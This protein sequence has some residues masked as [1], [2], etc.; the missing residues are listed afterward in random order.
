M[1]PTEELHAE[2]DSPAAE[3]ADWQRVAGTGERGEFCRAWLNIQA[4]LV[5]SQGVE[6]SAG[7]VLLGP[8]DSGPFTPA[9]VWPDRRIDA[10]YLSATAERALRDR[11]GIVSP[12]GVG[13]DSSHVAYPL[14]V[15]GHL[16]GVVVLDI[17]TDRDERLQQV[18]RNLHWG[19]GRLETLLAQD[20]T[21][22]A[23]QIIDRLVLNLD[24]VT[25]VG[26]YPELR[27]A[28][29][30][31]VTEVASRLGCDRVSIGFVEGDH[32]DVLA[33]SHSAQFKQKA[34]V[35]RAIGAAMDEAI[36][37]QQRVVLPEPES[38]PA[39]VMR[40]AQ[41]L[42]DMNGGGSVCVLPLTD[43]DG[44]VGA[45]LLESSQ[46]GRFDTATLELCDAMAALLGPVMQLQRANARPLWRRLRDTARDTL[47]RFFGPGHLAWKLSGLAVAALLAVLVLVPGEYR[48]TADAVLEGKVL[49]AAVAP[50]DGYIETAP[51][52]A[53]EL[54]E[55]GELIATLDDKDLSVERQK[56]L[57]RR[58]Q[59]AKEQREAEAD[60][61]WAR[62]GI[63]MAQ[64]Q[65]AE[66]DLT[67][68][69]DQLSRTRITAP[70]DGVVVSGDLSQ[71]LG[72]PV[73]RGDVLFEIAPLDQY[74]VVLKV[75]ERDIE[76]LVAGQGGQLALTSMPG[77][78]MPL[79]VEVITPVTTAEEGANYFRVEAS[80]AEGNERL[81]PGMEGV[82]KI[83]IDE[84]SLLWIWTHRITDWLRL[85]FWSWW[86]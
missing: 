68:V 35:V 3:Q 82:A 51:V 59:L 19:T 41:N 30:A 55:A 81:R 56:I 6:L 15:S 2:L 33:V 17:A 4:R 53:G 74:R 73:Q 57:S 46:A 13:G 36:D 79:L 39:L 1:T 84:R 62:A 34:N 83:S 44:P 5:R 27:A 49:R 8:A 69:D 67:L 21:A 9:A 65:Q 86:P 66:A 7:L 63:L 78:E 45:L 32:S 61:E 72:A 26:E 16:H 40:A 70:F 71:S 31:L 50:F 25:V 85:W 77:D 42:V 28:G 75:D 20:D 29:R 23:L 52:K 48:V 18:L 10:T 54:V 58:A 14:E 11:R 80:L 38:A 22:R 60:R 24:L 12:A 76:D 37:Q 64:K 47:A 43:A